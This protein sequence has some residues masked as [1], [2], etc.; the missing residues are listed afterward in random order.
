M[1]VGFSTTATSLLWS[2]HIVY[3]CC[4]HHRRRSLMERSTPNANGWVAWGFIVDNRGKMVP[5][6]HHHMH[7]IQVEV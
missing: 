6:H 3:N 7:N 4:H 1:S 5:Y 2:Q